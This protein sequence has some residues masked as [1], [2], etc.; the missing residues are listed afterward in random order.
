MTSKYDKCLTSFFCFRFIL[1]F[2]LTEQYNF[3]IE[4]ERKKSEERFKEL[5]KENDGIIMLGVPLKN[6]KKK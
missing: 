5:L 6:Q 1:S 4:V 2:V 3:I